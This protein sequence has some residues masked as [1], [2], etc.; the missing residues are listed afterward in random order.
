MRRSRR[1]NHQRKR[2][3]F[4]VDL[5]IPK[6]ATINDCLHYVEEAVTSWCSIEDNMFG[7]DPEKVK[8]KRHIERKSYTGEK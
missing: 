5:V 8:V 1:N 3:A 6:G 4:V 2:V 7:L